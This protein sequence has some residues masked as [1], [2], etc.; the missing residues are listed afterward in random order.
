MQQKTKVAVIGG[1]GK[2]GKYLVQQL[3]NQG[4]HFKML[5]RN[6]DHFQNTSSNV[7]VVN[8]NVNDLEAVRSLLTDCD[9]VISTLGM[10][11]PNSEPDIFSRSTKHVLQVMKEYKLTRYIVITGL[12]VDTPFDSKSVNTKAATDWMKTNYP[13]S[14]ADKQ[15][16]YSLLNGSDIDWTLVRVPMII[17]TEDTGKIFDSLE[18]CPG[19]KISATDLALF[20][21]QQL[22]DKKYIQKAPFIANE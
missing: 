15:L 10:G 8:G 20:L 6:P 12:N 7:E 22:T 5:V 4:F 19:E 14:T 9:A 21:I 1:T 2:S 17:Q 13:K 16:E 11:I 18:D 3:I